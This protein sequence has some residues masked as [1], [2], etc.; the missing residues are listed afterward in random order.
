MQL[1]ML[2]IVML[3]LLFGGCVTVSVES[4]VGRD[5]TVERYRTVINTTPL[6][7]SLLVESAKEKG[8]QSL[9]DA[10]LS[11]V[12]EEYRDRVMYDEVWSEDRVSIVVEGRNFVPEGGVRIWKDGEF[13]VY[14]DSSFANFSGITLHYYLE[15]PGKIVDSNAN[16][17]KDNRAEWHLVGGSAVIYAKSEVP[18]IPGFDLLSGL[19]CISL[20]AW[21]LARL[22]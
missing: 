11:D 9:R 13:L 14:E 3:A 21:C 1:R 18:S 6:V 4:K 8:Y 12:D 20:S 15:M 17:V 22:R 5:C 10:I 2:A 16:V 7:Y 19:T